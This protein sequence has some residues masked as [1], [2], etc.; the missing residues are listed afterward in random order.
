M[1]WFEESTQPE[2]VKARGHVN[3]WAEQFTDADA[4]FL[5]R[6]RSTVDVDHKAALDELFVHQRLNEN[7]E[8]RYEE[9]G[10][11]P[12]FRSYQQGLPV[13]AIEVISLFTK[14][15]WS[16]QQVR[17]GRIADEIDK[18]VPLT[19]YFVR[20]EIRR[21]DATPSYK[22]LASWL[23]GQIDALPE[24]RAD[25]DLTS[26]Q[27]VYAT[28]AVELV[29]QFFPRRGDVAPAPDDRIVGMGSMIGGMINTGERLKVALTAKA[30]NRYEIG[31]QPFA[32]AV[33]IRDSFCSVD[34]LES[35]LYGGEQ[36]SFPSGDLSRRRDGFF[37]LSRNA[38]SGRNRR[39]STVF[40]IMNWLPWDPTVAAVYQLDNPFGEH[41]WP[42][43]LF[44]A[45]ARFGEVSRNGERVVMDWL[46]GRPGGDY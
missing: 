13:G 3:Q 9:G 30:G 18:R 45:S 33:G 8:V 35:A 25:A 28:E 41:P 24:P 15:E 39:V 32:I 10:V 40:A 16:E 17:E 43:G 22:S 36:V 6:L 34:Q 46:G 14:Q 23:A 37:G 38:P 21:H 26:L 29:F 42:D 11:G 7:A 31:E 5:A 12:D 20:F 1:R 2:A 44:P 4:N 19:R 27:A